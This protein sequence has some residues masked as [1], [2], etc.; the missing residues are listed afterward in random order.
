M[1][2]VPTGPD[3][4]PLW[5][6]QEWGTRGPPWKGQLLGTVVP[7]D[8]DRPFF[9]LENSIGATP[10]A[11]V[12]GDVHGARDR[13]AQRIVEHSRLEANKA[14]GGR[15]VDFQEARQLAEGSARRTVQKQRK[16]RR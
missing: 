4:R 8:A 13:L 5:D 10:P 12:K 15:A 1:S 14:A 7:L 11:P 2:T 3:G 9:A 6:V 16:Q